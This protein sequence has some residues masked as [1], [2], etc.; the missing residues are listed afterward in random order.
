MASAPVQ[1]EEG[2][3]SVASLP[4]TYDPNI[5]V[6]KHQGAP[7]GGCSIMYL[8]GTIGKCQ[9]YGEQGETETLSEI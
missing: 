5:T 9:V 1:C 2:T 8:A 3:Y 6:R 4:Q 7:N